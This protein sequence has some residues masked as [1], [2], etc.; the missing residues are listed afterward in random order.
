MEI[1]IYCDE[2]CHLPNDHQPIMVLGAIWCPK[3]EARRIAEQV[4]EIKK[5]HNLPPFFEI[6]WGKVSPGKVDFYLNLLD[7]FFEE[8]DL[9]FRGMIIPDKS[10]LRHE[11]HHQDHD[12]WYYKMFYVMLKEVLN[13]LAAYNIYLDIKDTK[14]AEKVRTFQRVLKSV[15]LDIKRVQ[16]VRSHEIEQVQLTDLMIG[17]ISYYWRDLKTSEAKLKLVKEMVARRGKELNRNSYRWEK[18][19]NIF[20]WKA[21]WGSDK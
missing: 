8:K 14:S 11:L 4:R 1:N 6:K 7:Y 19:V 18:K 5:R 17:I 9:H 10:K 15:Y 12:L 16:N 20:I 2:S 21:S 3:S 13:P